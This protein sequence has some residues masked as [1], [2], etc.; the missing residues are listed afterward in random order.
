L[1][2]RTRSADDDIE[3]I[4]QSSVG[5]SHLYTGNTAT[6][7]LRDIV[8]R[9]FRHIAY[10]SL[11]D[12]TGQVPPSDVTVTHSHYSYLFQCL[13]IFFHYNIE[14]FLIAHFHFLG[15]VTYKREFQNVAGFYVSQFEFAVYVCSHSICCSFYHHTDSCEFPGGID[16]F[17]CNLVS[18]L[19]LNSRCTPER[20]NQ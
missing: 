15:F 16:N 7:T 10:I 3:V 8:Y 14:S 5:R 11:A 6:Q 12:R 13:G 19:C 9:G 17:T 4:P 20:N 2:Q 1:R 18:R